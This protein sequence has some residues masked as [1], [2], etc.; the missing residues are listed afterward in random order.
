MEYLGHP[1][2]DEGVRPVERLVTAVREFPRTVDMTEVKRFVHL[3]GY[4]RKF[5]ASFGSVVDPLTRL[6]IYC[7]NGVKRKN[8]HLRGLEI[9]NY[10]TIATLSKLR[11]AFLP[12][13]SVKLSFVLTSMDEP[14]LSLR[15]IP[16]CA[17]A[18]FGWKIA[19]LEPALTIVVPSTASPVDGSMGG[20]ADDELMTDLVTASTVGA[21]TT[22]AA[23]T[24]KKRAQKM[25]APVTRRSARI[26]ERAQ[27]HEPQ[28]TVGAPTG[29][30]AT[31]STKTRAVPVVK[32]PAPRGKTERSDQRRV[33]TTVGTTT[34]EGNDTS[35]GAEVDSNTKTNDGWRE[36]TEN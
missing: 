30:M 1:L 31:E 12:V 14:L 5:I 9:V 24:G 36:T 4:Y 25:S 19:S 22:M 15:I 3:A 18:K 26:R 34:Y 28:V 20:T 35:D 29:T 21:S 13:W 23:M 11:F 10:A 17:T 6:L 27:Q 7:G 16:H 33:L 8:L 2:S 32:V